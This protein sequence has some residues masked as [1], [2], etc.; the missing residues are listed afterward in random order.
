VRPSFIFHWRLPPFTT[1][2]CVAL[3]HVGVHPG[4]ALEPV[5]HVRSSSSVAPVASSIAL[6]MDRQAKLTLYVDGKI[7]TEVNIDNLEVICIVSHLVTVSEVTRILPFL[8]E[9]DAVSAVLRACLAERSGVVVEI[10]LHVPICKNTNF[11]E[12]MPEIK[13][14]NIV[15]ERCAGEEKR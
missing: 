10:W 3:R 11:E 9:I 8:H 13:S 4:P 1:C 7:V 2:K 15:S 12:A 6:C 5:D 14:E